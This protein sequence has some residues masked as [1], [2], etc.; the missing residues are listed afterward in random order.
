MSR[1]FNELPLADSELSFQE[2]C[3]LKT[4]LDGLSRFLNKPGDWGYESQLG[5]LTIAIN[6]VKDNAVRRIQALREAHPSL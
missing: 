2:A 6:N 1:P 3:T 5:R 4:H